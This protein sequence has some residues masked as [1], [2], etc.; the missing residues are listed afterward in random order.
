MLQIHKNTIESRVSY[1]VQFLLRSKRYNT[2]FLLRKKK[3]ATIHLRAPKHFNIGKQRILSLN[4]TA[5][6]LQLVSKRGLNLYSFIYN[7]KH[8][9]FSFA[10]KIQ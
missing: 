4:Y 9:Y 6:N 2:E 1:G 10:K 7:D 8:L 3:Q 5:V